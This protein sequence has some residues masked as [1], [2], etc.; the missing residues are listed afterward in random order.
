M[1]IYA[2]DFKHRYGSRLVLFLKVFAFPYVT[3][4]Q[5][6]ATML[7]HLG[8]EIS[9]AGH[10]EIGN[11]DPQRSFPQPPHCLMGRDDQQT[12]VIRE[13]HISKLSEEGKGWDRKLNG[14]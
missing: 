13:Y 3:L 5:Y 4:A 6:F 12:G 11:S 1:S 9:L 8:C 2:A 10:C 14:D 7:V